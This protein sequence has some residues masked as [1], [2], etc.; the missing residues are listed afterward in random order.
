MSD[1]LHLGI[2]V[3]SASANT[4]IMNDDKEVL[5]EE[6]TRTKGQPLETVA[7]VLTG[8]FSRFPVEGIK[9]VSFTGSGGGL[10]AKLLGSNF[11]NEIIAQ[12]RAISFYHP[13]VRTVIEM[14]GE[15]S[16][17]ILLKNTTAGMEIEDFA[18]NT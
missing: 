2:D 8:V 4:V 5:L 7:R 14:G 16:K 11:T 15:D 6:Y 18:M 1:R 17:L 3:G 12:A 13:E 10:L 9:T